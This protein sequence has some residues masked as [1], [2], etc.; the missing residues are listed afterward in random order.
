MVLLMHFLPH[1]ENRKYVQ[2]RRNHKEKD[3]KKERKK[4]KRDVSKSEIESDK[5]FINI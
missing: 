3:R 5:K 4:R 1:S 2:K